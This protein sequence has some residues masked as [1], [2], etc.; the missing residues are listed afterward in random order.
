MSTVKP[1][2]SAVPNPP[3]PRRSGTTPNVVM[4]LLSDPARLGPGTAGTGWRSGRTA[5]R[6]PECPQLPLHCARQ[7]RVGIP[8]VAG[9]PG[10]SALTQYADL[11]VNLFFIISGFVVLITAWGRS[12]AWLHSLP[13]ARLFPAYWFSVA[14]TTGLLALV[15][16]PRDGLSRCGSPSRT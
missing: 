7:P 11:G 13:V 16:W 1:P 2:R 8:P 14:V 6:G 4:A 5:S 9:V 12:T 10:I 15:L 3:P